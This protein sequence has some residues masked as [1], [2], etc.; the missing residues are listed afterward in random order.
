MRID[1]AVSME[2]QR[3]DAIMENLKNNKEWLFA[4]GG[5]IGRTPM[6]TKT[7]LARFSESIR[8]LHLD[9]KAMWDPAFAGAPKLFARCDTIQD[10]ADNIRR[11]EEYVDKQK[12]E[13]ARIDTE[14]G[15][16]YQP[17]LTAFDPTRYRT[18]KQKLGFWQEFLPTKSIPLG[19][20]DTKYTMYEGT[21]QT[22]PSSPGR[23]GG[24]EYV[25]VRSA[26]FTNPIRTS[27]IGYMLTTDDQRKAA[28]ANEPLM[29]E[30]LIATKQALG[31]ML[32]RIAWQ[33][34]DVL[35]L[36]GAINH[37]GVANLQ[38]SAPGTGSDRTWVGTDKT[39]DEK[40][41]DVRTATTTIATAS[42][43]NWRP[44][45]APFNMLIS[46]SR[47]SALNVRMAA[48]TDTTLRKYILDPRNGAGVAKI[49]VLPDE[50]I[51]TSGPANSQQALYY[52]ND[53]GVLRYRINNDIIWAP[54]QWV[55][56]TMKFP[57]EIIHGSVEVIYPVAMIELYGI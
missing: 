45:D 4:M 41:A 6:E 52:P 55:D 44:E 23:M 14:E 38:A 10:R 35:G 12:L 25:G 3:V 16:F 27:T 31:R 40:F 46:R 53:P 24:I 30:L 15:I 28:Y 5:A 1:S 21:G 57:G 2:V 9:C 29:D 54:M 42:K 7:G 11:I 8:K 19:A 32:D 56:L 39:N 36:N 33:G 26:R 48:G 20:Q 49:G 22:A 47:N 17:D 34:D 51:A 13:L 37:P 43:E 50:F 18:L